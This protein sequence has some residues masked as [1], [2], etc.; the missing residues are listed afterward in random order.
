MPRLFCLSE[1]TSTNTYCA[2]HLEELAHGDAVFTPRQ[3]AGKGRGGRGWKE[4]EGGLYFT[5]VLKEEL[6]T[7]S[8]LPLYIALSVS[9]AIQGMTGQWPRVKWPNDLL[10]NGKKICGILCECYPGGFVCGVGLNLNQS[11]TFFIQQELAYGTSV[12]AETGV[13]MGLQKAAQDLQTQILQRLSPFAEQGF[14]PFLAEYESAC[15]NLGRRVFWGDL[16]G[17]AVGIG[18]G[19][20]LMVRLPDGA[21]TALTGEVHLSGFYGQS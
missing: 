21:V 14:A 13:K 3:T 1:A 15:A 18:R 19:G 11:P 20:E 12:Y 6:C 17:T 4:G 5:M 8:A 10:W 2:Q 16:S 9:A 7:P